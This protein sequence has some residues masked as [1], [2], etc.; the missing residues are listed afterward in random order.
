[1][2]EEQWREAWE[3]V[4][5]SQS[6]SPEECRALLISTG[7][8]EEVL[9]KLV[10]TAGKQESSSWNESSNS[11]GVTP[12]TTVGRYEVVSPLGRGGMGEV[13]LAHDPE[14]GRKAALKFLVPEKIDVLAAQRFLR[15]ARAASALNHPNIVTVYEVVRHNETSVIAMEFIEGASLRGLTPVA[16][17]QV[18]R[19]G[20]QVA[21]ALSAAHAAGIVHR[22]IK[23]ENI[24]VRP[25]GYVKV[26]DFGL[27]RRMSG[28]TMTL[29]TGIVLGTL[30]Y[31]S[32]EQTRGESAGSASDIFSLGLVL[33]ELATG[34]HPFAAESPLQTAHAIST[35]PPARLQPTDSKIPRRFESLIFAMLEKDPPARPAA[36]EVAEALASISPQTEQRTLR[37]RLWIGVLA[38][39]LIMAGL[40]AGLVAGLVALFSVSPQSVTLEATPFTIDSGIEIEPAF[41]PDGQSLAY[42]WNGPGEDN[43]DIYIKPAGGGTQFRLTD[44]AAQDYCP[45]WSPDGRSIAFLR[46]LGLNRAEVRVVSASG[47]TERKIGEIRSPQWG[48]WWF[49]GPF[50]KWSPHSRWLVVSTKHVGP[51]LA[52]SLQ[53]MSTE[54]GELRRLSEGEGLGGDSAPAFSPDGRTLVFTRLVAEGSA[55]LYL[56]QLSPEMEP[57]GSPRRLETGKPW[58]TT[59]AWTPDGGEIV[60]S[61]G[62]QY[63]TRLARVTPWRQQMPRPLAGVGE[64]GCYPAISPARN[65]GAAPDLTYARHIKTTA[66]WRLALERDRKG[67]PTSTKTPVRVIP[68]VS[69][70]RLVNWSPDGR[71]FAYIS[72][73]SG[74]PEVWVADHDGKSA[75]QWTFLQAGEVAD[76]RWSPDGKQVLF[77]AVVKDVTSLY[78]TAGPE[79]PARPL[80]SEPTYGGAWSPDGQ[81]IFYYPPATSEIWRMPA[82]G[83]TPVR[84][85]EESGYN[86]QISPAGDALYFAKIREGEVWI[87]RMRLDTSSLANRVAQPIIR[88]ADSYSVGKRGIYFVPLLLPTL[89]QEDSLSFFDFATGSISP[90]AKVQPGI[91]YQISVSRDERHVLYSRKEF[92]TTN[93]MTVRGFR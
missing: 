68:P 30:R 14:L 19:I 87:W 21:Q 47:G 43:F 80:R 23:P 24:M 31:V 40:M 45:T 2:N 72:P 73:R 85:S 52:F 20:L 32:P 42:V 15:E 59:P 18:V 51:S 9:L 75:T 78:L 76:P 86:L 22:D 70:D 56:L 53:L 50:L 88:M 62:T 79:T 82:A 48:P 74:F 91:Q 27:A 54:N 34:R 7:I 64:G 35:A 92:E 29:S 89:G 66:I 6:L 57:L 90:V 26:L 71:R 36:A 13:W 1:M 12:G 69:E 4:E 83:G 38:C 61:T 60:F 3:I 25:D 39:A 77:R 93:L 17:S 37:R 84:I 33:Y 81:W 10:A 44:N 41:S 67:L 55:Y 58:N 63:N 8:D 65:G 5:K 28:A 16:P 49:P 46:S 11:T